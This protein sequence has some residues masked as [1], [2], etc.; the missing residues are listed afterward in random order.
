LRSRW[1]RL[2]GGQGNKGASDREDLF[3]T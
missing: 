2:S 1:H 3:R